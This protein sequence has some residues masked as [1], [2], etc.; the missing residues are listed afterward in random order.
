MRGVRRGAVRA[1]AGAWAVANASDGARL[2]LLAKP[3]CAACEA[4]EPV[5]RSIAAALDLPWGREHTERADAPIVLLR[6][7]GAE[8]TLARTLVEP[9]ALARSARRALGRGAEGAHRESPPGRADEE[10][11]AA[12]AGDLV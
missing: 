12:G 8:T 6:T 11:R 2:V 10:N 7:D 1:G 4:A 5:V 9:A 3:D